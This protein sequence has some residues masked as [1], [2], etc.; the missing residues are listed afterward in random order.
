MTLDVLVIV[1]PTASGK[2]RL[3]V[4]VAHRLGSEIV[5]A[6][7]RQVY[8]G[9]DIGTGKDLREYAAVSRPVPYH[10]IDVA[11]PDEVYS[12]FRFQQD[13]YRVFREMAGRAPFVGGDT[14]AVL[15]GGSGLYIEAVVRQYR[16][17]DVP[18][19]TALR[20]RLEVR[21]RSE[22]AA[23]LLQRWPDLAAETDMS[24]TRRIIRAYEI[25][26]YRETQSVRYGDPP[27]VAL[28]FRVFGIAVA[29]QDLRHR[30]R[31]RLRERLE[32]GM[33]E[34]VQHLLDRGLSPRR[35][36]DL[37]LEY[38]EIAAYLAGRKTREQMIS[39]LEIAIGRFAK[40]QQTWFRG[41]AR[42]G[43]EIRW[44]GA[45]D[46]DQVVAASGVRR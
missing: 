9:L 2:T 25:G 44:I 38:R 36:D 35:L 43:V 18:K 3:G 42:R 16:L 10:L 37:G 15:V 28:R 40:R 22:L 12:L 8:R 1:G 41:M 29:R 13:C 39:D 27:G 30:I 24:S 11:D 17:A 5:S 6:D 45:D 19:N 14:P 20:A 7:S 46:V 33:V 31:R 21:D 34:E 4:Q 26:F 32:Q 23:E